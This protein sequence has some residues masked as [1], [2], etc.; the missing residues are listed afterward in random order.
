[1]H[2]VD[3]AKFGMI[4]RSLLS[5]GLGLGLVAVGACSAD[6]VSDGCPPGYLCIEECPDGQICGQQNVDASTPIDSATPD[7]SDGGP[8]AYPAGSVPPTDSKA[9]SLAHDVIDANATDHVLWM[10]SAQPSAA[11]YAWTAATETEQTIPLA[12]PPVALAISP[13]QT[14]I[15]VIDDFGISWIDASSKTITKTCAISGGKDVAVANNGTAFVLDYDP[16][17]GATTLEVVDPSDC[18][19]TDGGLVNPSTSLVMHANSTQ[20]FTTSRYSLLRCD[21]TVNPPACVEVA[22]RDDEPAG[23]QLWPSLEL[24]RI[25]TTGGLALDVWAGGTFLD[26]VTFGGDVSVDPVQDVREVFL[27]PVWSVAA[28]SLPETGGP[29]PNSD[30]VIQLMSRDY[31]IHS[32][33]LQIPPMSPSE[34]EG[35][36][37]GRF[38]FSFPGGDIPGATL[39]VVVQSDVTHDF[40]L[41]LLTK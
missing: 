37:H 29:P 31:L 7:A 18:G 39:A 25:Y 21:I 14:A 13:G 12:H 35:S 30:A 3:G 17:G 11:I 23:G 4:T 36:A 41:E 34:P 22:L 32:P 10:A 20:L 2:E 9:I 33:P 24:E 19:T 26:A 38:V 40:G 27:P 8:S 1:M 5:A 28:I 15:V 16:D 6:V